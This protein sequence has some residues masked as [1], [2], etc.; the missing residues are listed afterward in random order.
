MLN[1]QALDALSDGIDQAVD[2]TRLG[3][4]TG[5]QFRSY[6]GRMPLGRIAVSVLG[7]LCENLLGAAGRFNNQLVVGTFRG[8][9]DGHALWR[10]LVRLMPLA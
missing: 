4:Q 1:I 8:V 9:I 7:G 6:R 5:S 3:R 2:P 10:R